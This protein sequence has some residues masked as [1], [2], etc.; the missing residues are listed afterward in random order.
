MRS[1]LTLLSF[2]AIMLWLIWAINRNA[3]IPQRCIKK[4]E[5]SSHRAMCVE[6]KANSALPSGSNPG[7]FTEMIGFAP[8]F[9]PSGKPEDSR[10]RVARGSQ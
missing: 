9:F 7:P 1:Y 3:N 8:P 6:A 10:S 5:K 2:V 4:V